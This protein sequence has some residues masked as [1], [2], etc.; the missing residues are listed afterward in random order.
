M[1]STRQFQKEKEMKKTTSIQKK[2][3]FPCF[4]I[5][6]RA[7]REQ[8]NEEINRHREKERKYSKKNTL[9]S[10]MIPPTLRYKNP[11][12]NTKETQLAQVHVA[13]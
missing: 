2:N 12:T 11:P 6:K 8:E 4:H 7:T 5:L 3:L 10:Q 9:R 1:F 13:P